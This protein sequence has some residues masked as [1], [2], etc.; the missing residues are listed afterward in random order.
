MIRAATCYIDDAW[1]ASSD[2][3]R[4]D[5]HSR[6][7]M[8]N[9]KSVALVMWLVAGFSAGVGIYGAVRGRAT[10]TFIAV[11]VVFFILGIAAKRRGAESA[12]RRPND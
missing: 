5:Q 11:A 3:L 2:S 1:V 8:A 4:L 6:D 12:P 9:P 10:G 7:L